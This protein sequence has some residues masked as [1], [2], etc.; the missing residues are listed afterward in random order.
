M[1]AS[2]ER[3]D[4]LQVLFRDFYRLLP[5]VCGKLPLVKVFYQAQGF[6]RMARTAVYDLVMPA[7]PDKDCDSSL[8]IPIRFVSE[9]S[10]LFI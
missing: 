9:F 10:Y 2:T 7:L 6:C 1:T 8:G 3:I 5:K 4:Q